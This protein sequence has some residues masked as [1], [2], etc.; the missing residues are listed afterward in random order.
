LERICIFGTDGTGALEHLYPEFAGCV[1]NLDLSELDARLR[2]AHVTLSKRG[3]TAKIPEPLYQKPTSAPHYW[4]LKEIAAEF[5]PCVWRPEDTTM[6]W[7][8]AYRESLDI[9]GQRRNDYH[10]FVGTPVSRP[11]RMWVEYERLEEQFQESISARV[12]ETSSGDLRILE[13]EVDDRIRLKD[14]LKSFAGEADRIGKLIHRTEA[15]QSV[16]HS[17]SKGF[18]EIGVHMFSTS[19]GVSQYKHRLFSLR[20]TAKERIFRVYKL[21]LVQPQLKCPVAIRFVFQ[22][23]DDKQDFFRSL[24]SCD[25]IVNSL[26]WMT[27]QSDVNLTTESINRKFGQTSK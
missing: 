4:M 18:E 16:N 27:L 8:P 7:S 9:T 13:S 12:T 17:L 14:E 1:I 10:T 2:T 21:G 23:E 6:M 22:F 15:M 19:D 24:P 25:F 20:L 5:D 3:V 11:I 26:R